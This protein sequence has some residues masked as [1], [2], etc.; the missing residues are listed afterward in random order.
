MF[1][2]TDTVGYIDPIQQWVIPPVRRKALA[3]VYHRMTRMVETETREE[4]LRLAYNE[5]WVYCRDEGYACPE[6]VQAFLGRAVHLDSDMLKAV[7]HQMLCRLLM[8]AACM[9]QCIKACCCNCAA[10]PD[11]IACA[12]RVFVV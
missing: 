7:L 1:E 8:Q 3:N 11:D 5:M 6:L 4:F 12:K 9:P 2:K 10:A